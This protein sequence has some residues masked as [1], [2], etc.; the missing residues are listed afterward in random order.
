MSTGAASDGAML[1][2]KW[3]GELDAKLRQLLIFVED[4]LEIDCGR[5]WTFAAAP[6]VGIFANLQGI[7]K[8][9]QDSLELAF[10]RAITSAT[11]IQPWHGVPF[12]PIHS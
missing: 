6:A 9:I 4:C 1:T 11:K 3:H 7:S 2:R 8:E 10:K 12:K 5:F